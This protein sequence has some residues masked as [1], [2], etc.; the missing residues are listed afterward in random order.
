MAQF[1]KLVNTVN[2]REDLRTNQRSVLHAF[3]WRKFPR[4]IQVEC[5]ETHSS[6]NT[7]VQIAETMV[8]RAGPFWLAAVFILLM[9]QTR[10]GN[11]AILEEGKFV[12][13]FP[14]ECGGINRGG[15]PR[16]LKAPRGAPKVDPDT[17]G[18]K[19]L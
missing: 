11:V 15:T 12:L 14:T 17:R 16:V 3:E 2:A 10:W 19:S 1:E 4:D 8:R 13:G 6:L 5:I 18:R 9:T 7:E